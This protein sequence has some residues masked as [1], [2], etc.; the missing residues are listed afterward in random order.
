MNIFTQYI[1]SKKWCPTSGRQQ[2]NAKMVLYDRNTMLSYYTI[3][4]EDT[5]TGLTDRLI[6]FIIL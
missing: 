3:R 5:H 4:I 1:R 2:H 6:L